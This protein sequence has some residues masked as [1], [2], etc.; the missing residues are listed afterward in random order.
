MG[1]K[2]IRL[3]V[4][5]EDRRIAALAALAVGLSL[6]EA[7]LPSPIP[8]IKPGLANIVILLVMLRY[9]FRTA[10]WVMA[11]RL[12]AASLLLGYFL[13]PGFWLACAGAL[14]SM[15]VLYLVRFLPR[16]LFGPVSFSVLMA[17]A[18]VCGQLLLAKFWLFAEAD[19]G[20]LMPVFAL[21]ALVFGTVNGLIVARLIADD[22]IPGAQS[23]HV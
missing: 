12:L 13:A 10:V 4:T 11:V 20:V 22:S 1:T 3:A 2:E 23:A 21:A 7:A 17:F 14:A 18:H 15:G 9:G 5:Q 8:G 19:I 16:A 6:A